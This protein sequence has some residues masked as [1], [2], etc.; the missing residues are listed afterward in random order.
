MGVLYLLL[1]I[2]FTLLILAFTVALRLVFV[3]DTDSERINLTLFWLYPFFK[4][5]VENNPSGLLLK[6]FL[7]K[8]KVYERPLLSGAGSGNGGGAR[9]ARMAEPE[10]IRINAEYGFSDPFV[11]GITCGAISAA[12]DNLDMVS[13]RQKPDFVSGRDYVQMDATAGINLG[14]MLVKLIGSK[15]KT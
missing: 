15:F 10:N 7:F 3:L 4:A 13:L 2:L 5:D 8:G 14:N 6:I 1:L 12:A 9:L 11:T